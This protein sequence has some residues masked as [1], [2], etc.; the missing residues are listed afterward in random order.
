M[1]PRLGDAE[2]LPGGLEGKPPDA[3]AKQT[4]RASFLFTVLLKD[5]RARDTIYHWGAEALTGYSPE[6]YEARP[7][8]WLDMIPDEDRMRVLDQVRLLQEGR[9][10]PPIEHR[11]IRK[12]GSERWV[13]NLSVPRYDARGVLEAYDGLLLDITETRGYREQLRTLM[14]AI[15]Q[16]P[17]VVVVTDLEGRIEYVNPKFEALTG[18]TRAEVLGRQPN[19]LKSGMEP[20]GLYQDMWTALKAGKEWRGEYR[21]KRKDG[22]LYW[23]YASLSAVRDMEGRITHFIKVAEDVT[24]RKRAEDE[25]DEAMNRLRHAAHRDA[26]TGL[27]NRRGFE[28]RLQQAWLQGARYREPMGAIIMDIDRFKTINDAYGHL[29]GDEIIEGVASLL[30]LATREADIVARYG[31]DEFLII[32]PVTKA[33]DVLRV[34]QRLLDGLRELTFCPATHRLRVTASIGLAHGIPGERYTTPEALIQQADQA[35]YRAKRLGRDRLCLSDDARATL[36]GDAPAGAELT[37]SRPR[38]LIVDDDL[39]VAEV[40]CRLLKSCDWDCDR[41]HKAEPALAAVENS[42]GRYAMALVDRNLGEGIDGIELLRRM[43]QTD[44]TMVGILITGDATTEA[45]IEAL[46]AG[47]VDFLSKPI[48]FDALNATLERA[49]KYRTLLLENDH[50]QRHLQDMVREKSAALSETLHALDV[51]YE[52]TLETL[53]AMLDARES[54]TGE[55][56]KRV[57][58][59]SRFLAEKAGLSDPEVHVVAQGALLHDIGKIAIP[60]HILLKPG[61]LNDEE[62]EAMRAHPRVGYDILKNAPAFAQAARIVLEH[63]ERWDGDGYPDGLSGEAICL[64]ARIFAV[65]DAYDAMRA[66]RPY[67]P[68]MPPDQAAEELKRHRGQQFDPSVVDL[69]L[70]HQ[71]AI[72]D[73]GRWVDPDE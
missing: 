11:L 64:G 66:E 3:D 71:E 36:A 13:L 53:A 8:L 32:L 4:A 70:K 39:G 72:E 33:E 65:V 26:L 24:A 19:V 1:Q 43:R 27:L 52:A 25:R 10:A 41:A 16:S 59:V 40:L 20:E 38:A 18:Y 2:T 68:P 62:R 60:D 42:R 50:Y 73:I 5:G 49:A 54:K 15:E 47:A 6:E 7:L 17:S 57:M 61:P 55:H 35:M 34:A 23:E 46:R 12:D 29:A 58:R 56:S 45:A 44:H 14:H 9:S 67:Q 63:Q 51:S 28:D 31:G 37:A 22:T 21:N 69:F 48:A 30:R